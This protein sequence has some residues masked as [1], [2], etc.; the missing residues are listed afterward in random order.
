MIHPTLEATSV[1]E[2]VFLCYRC[3]TRREKVNKCKLCLWYN[4][5]IYC[6]DDIPWAVQDEITTMKVVVTKG[7]EL[8]KKLIAV[9]DEQINKDSTSV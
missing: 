3:Y 5:N 1:T 6:P 8:S 9:E 4:C 2:K 7:K